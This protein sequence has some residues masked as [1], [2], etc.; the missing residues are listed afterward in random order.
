MEVKGRDARIA[1]IAENRFPSSDTPV[2]ISAVMIILI[3]Y[4]M[5]LSDYREDHSDEV[6]QKWLKSLLPM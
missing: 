6:L 5:F 4:C 1:P 3:R 2:T